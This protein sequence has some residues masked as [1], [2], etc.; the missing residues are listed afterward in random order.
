MLFV[1]LGLFAQFLPISV[2][3]ENVSVSLWLS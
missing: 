2:A 1:T 3:A